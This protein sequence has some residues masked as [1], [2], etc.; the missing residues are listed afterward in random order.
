[1]FLRQKLDERKFLKSKINEL[2]KSILHFTDEQDELIKELLILFD[3]LQTINLVLNK[4]NYESVIVIADT[5]L[6]LNTAV[7]LR[8]A[9]Q[10]KI[11][12]MTDLISSCEGNLDVMSLMEQRDGVIEEFMVIDSAIRKAD[13]NIKI[14]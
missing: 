2:K 6:S 3:R 5:E 9:L 10:S 1:M 12:M 7:E 8:N 4:V 14:E 11:D 13:W